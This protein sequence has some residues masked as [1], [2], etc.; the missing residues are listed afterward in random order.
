MSAE[1][2]TWLNNMTLI[3]NTDVKGTAWH[4]RAEEQGDESNHYPGAIPVED[5]RRR[6]FFWT[7]VEGTSETTIVTESGVTHMT[8]PDR[9]QI[10]RLPGTFGPDDSGSVLGVFKQGFQIH[11][12]SQWLITNVSNILD[13]GL[14]VGSAGL[15]KGGAVAWVQV[16]VPK[17]I[18][19]P[20]GVEFMPFVTAATSVDGSLSSTY[21]RGAQLVVCDN[22]LSAGLSGASNKIKVKHSRNSLGKITEV[23]Q[24]LDIVYATGDDFATQVKEL[25]ETPVSNL[26][27]K[28]F[29]DAYS[30]VSDDKGRGQTMAQNKQDTLLKLWTTDTRVSPWT[31]TAF[32]VVQAVN[33][34]VHHEG[35]VRGSDRAQRNALRVV[36]GGVDKLDADTLEILNKVLVN[37]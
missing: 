17:T 33:T 22:T 15:L 26:M 28:K 16:E 13:D 34:Y 7:P 8:D 21:I 19:T 36:T 25:C 1:T 32:G 27:F 18:T 20:E 5:V 9:K 30:P 37:A 3:G 31:N 35:I 4:Y 14:S 11:D 24:A 23:R 12:Y 6:L 2:S 29:L 10:V